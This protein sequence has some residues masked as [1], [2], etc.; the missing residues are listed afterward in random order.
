MKREESIKTLFWSGH[1]NS[2]WM[3]HVGQ[4]KKNIKRG[5]PGQ[6]TG[7]KEYIEGF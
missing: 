7:G 2:E 5:N 6:R 1:V 4:V 3:D